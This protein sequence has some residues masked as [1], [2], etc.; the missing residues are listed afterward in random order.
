[1]LVC[2]VDQLDLFITH[3]DQADWA[4]YC[5]ILKHF[6]TPHL[7]PV[8]VE[9]QH[10]RFVD[11]QLSMIVSLIYLLRLSGQLELLSFSRINLCLSL[12]S[13][14]LLSGKVDFV[15]CKKKFMFVID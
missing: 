4:E 8:P 1:M 6:A 15:S 7:F 12:F 5:N 13:A 9:D 3:Y 2:K 14:L 11:E 10:L